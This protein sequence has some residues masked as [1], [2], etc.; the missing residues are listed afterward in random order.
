M[1]PNY[2]SAAEAAK[3]VDVCSATIQY[4]FKT[5]RIERFERVRSE[6]S[7]RRAAVNKQPQY[8]FDLNQVTAATKDGSEA[9]LRRAHP[10][11]RF[12]D[13]EGLADLLGCGYSKAIH[14]MSDSGVHRYSYYGTANTYMVDVHELMERI[15]VDQPV[16]AYILRK[17]L[18]PR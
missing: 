4:W 2:V 13:A 15:T 3:A 12:V 16:E 1:N 14:L 10:D 17:K 7:K 8:W 5:G 18:G 9:A 11:V 6:K